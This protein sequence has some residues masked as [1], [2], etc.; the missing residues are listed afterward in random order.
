MRQLFNEEAEQIILGTIIV[1]NMYYARVSDILEAKHFIVVDHQK[2][3][4]KI[5]DGLSNDDVSDQ[6][7]LGNFFAN[8]I[9]GGHEYLRQLLSKASVIV[10]IRKYAFQV[11]ELAKKRQ[12][13]ELL[14]TLNNN[15]ESA[16]LVDV[17]NQLD[18]GITQIDTTAENIQLFGVDDL[19]QDWANNIEKENN[20]KPIPTKLPSL[21]KMLNGGLQKGGLYVLAASSGGGKTFFSQNIILNALKCDLGAYFVSMEMQKRKIFTRFIAMIAQI[22]SFR[23][24][25]GN[26]YQHEEPIL[27]DAIKQWEGYKKTFLI[28]DLVKLSAT[29]IESALKRAI[30]KQPIDLMVIDYAQIMELSDAR[31][32]NEASLIKENVVKLAQIAKKYDISILLLSQ[33]TKDKISGRVGLGS[34][35]GSGGLYEDADCV[36]AMWAEED[37]PKNVWK[38]LKIEVLKNRDGLSGGLDVDFDGEFGK[39]TEVT[40][41]DF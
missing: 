13:E 23:I 20:L 29:K 30:R 4:Q 26:I 22:N 12:L 41:N 7:T 32:M 8:E 28:T 39:F 33:L 16:N 1:K 14:T 11:L 2:I 6:V 25:K 21:D 5:V 24:L 37:Q 40:N 10:D 3:Y 15:L 36:I 19:V 27:Q 18:A 31:N 34:L 17:M 9:N 35:K 38:K